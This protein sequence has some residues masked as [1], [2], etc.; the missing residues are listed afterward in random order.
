MRFSGLLLCVCLSFLLLASCSTA[1]QDPAGVPA[2]PGD[3]Q[4]ALKALNDINRAQADFIRRTRRYAQTTQELIADRL[5]TT[6]PEAEG[7]RIRMVP[8]PDAVSYTAEATPAES[9][10][11]H[12]FT[13]KTGIIRVE[14]GKPATA[15][16][17]EL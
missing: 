14:T 11:R 16:S 8:S 5:L 6:E 7:Y 17:P 4:A 3:E 2:K 15:T 12:F 13:D 1:D 9:A 10:G